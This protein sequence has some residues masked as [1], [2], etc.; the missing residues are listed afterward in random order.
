MVD[1]ETH[2]DAAET[3][4]GASGSGAGEAAGGAMAQV[5]AQALQALAESSTTMQKNFD[6]MMTTLTENIAK[7]ASLSENVSKSTS[8]DVTK[9][10]DTNVDEAQANASGNLTSNQT[11]L[12]NLVNNSMA[13]HVDMRATS[14]NRHVETLQTILTMNLAATQFATN[15]C[16]NILVAEIHQQSGRNADWRSATIPNAPKPP[17]DA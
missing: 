17:K 16:Q 13:N 12:S 7:V 5:A 6:A 14:L 8:E 3:V 15:V 2:V 10:Q 11:A 4:G 9:K 1:S